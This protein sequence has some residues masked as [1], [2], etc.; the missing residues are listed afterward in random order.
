MHPSIGVCYTP[1]AIASDLIENTLGQILAGKTPQQLPSLK[2]LD[3]ACGEGALLIPAYQY[4]LNWYSQHSPQPLTPAQRQQILCNHIYGVDI[5]I[6]AVETTQKLLL[7]QSLN[8]SENLPQLSLDNNIKVGNA[9]IGFNWIQEFPEIMKTRGFD[10]IIG[11]PPY[12]DSE[13]MMAHL[14]AWRNYCV[15]QYQTAS[16][17]WDLF[18]I[19]V[20]LAMNL[21]K[22]DGL[23]SFIVP[24]KISSAQY[25]TKT[26]EILTIHNQ[27]LAIRDYSRVPVFPVNVYP[28]V[29]IA[30]KRSPQLSQPV[31]YEK[32]QMVSGDRIQP[33]LT[34]QLNYSRHFL[35]P[36]KPWIM[37]AET[38]DLD[39]INRLQSQFP[40]L[41]TVATV[42]GAATVA[43]AYQIQP[44]IHEKAT[45]L[46]NDLKLVNS[47]TIDRYRLLWGHKKFRYLGKTYFHPIIPQA[48]QT[49]LPPKRWQQAQHPK[50]IVAG[51]G[52]V[53]EGA[54]DVQGDYLAGKSTV[55]ILSPTLDL[56]YLL[57]ILNSQL[58]SF[59]Y[60][61]VFAGDSLN[62]GYLRVGVQQLRSLPIPPLHPSL[63]PNL[64]QLVNQRLNSPCDCLTLES[65]IEQI[66]YQLYELTPSEIEILKTRFLNIP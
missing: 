29:Y 37:N 57:A 38:G 49:Q 7:L 60:R 41:H 15:N 55:I 8:S 56:R 30:K 65:Q 22:P 58:L 23:N 21:C 42:C 62:G 4:L 19:F 44:L 17:N 45:H 18:C 2:I 39:F 63:T 31:K 64:L 48:L 26:R 50:L 14:P 43:E 27:L 1:P 35:T 53:L 11:N 16:G 54:M 51:M 66:I 61:T 36:E 25:A 46:K 34:R 10:L 12:V 13:W 5:D 52:K 20:E 6:Q 47:G 33:T 59:Y 28:L 40:C 24:N 32:M 3:P 9:I